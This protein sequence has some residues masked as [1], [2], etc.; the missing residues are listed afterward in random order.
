VLEYVK[1]IH[2]NLEEYGAENKERNKR[3]SA[4]EDIERA[5][6]AITLHTRIQ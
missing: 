4:E 6:V 2:H 3:E 5:G 1:R